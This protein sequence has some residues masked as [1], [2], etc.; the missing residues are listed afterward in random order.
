MATEYPKGCLSCNEQEIRTLLLARGVDINRFQAVPTPRHQW[1]DISVCGDCGQAWL[2]LPQVLPTACAAG[3]FSLHP[4]ETTMKSDEDEK[5]D[6]AIVEQALAEVERA[7]LVCTECGLDRSC[8]ECSLVPKTDLRAHVRLLCST[9][10]RR[11][12]EMTVMRERLS[13]ERTVSDHRNAVIRSGDHYF[14]CVQDYVRWIWSEPRDVRDPKDTRGRMRDAA[15]HYR[16]TRHDLDVRLSRAASVPMTDSNRVAVLVEALHRIRYAKEEGNTLVDMVQ[17]LSNIVGADPAA[18]DE[19]LQAVRDEQRVAFLEGLKTLGVPVKYYE[20]RPGPP[21]HVVL[22]VDGEIVDPTEYR[23]Y[24]DEAA[25]ANAIVILAHTAL[26]P[27]AA[28]ATRMEKNCVDGRSQ[29]PDTAEPVGTNGLTFGNVCA[30]RSLATRISTYLKDYKGDLWGV[31]A[32][33]GQCWAKNDHIMLLFPN[34]EEAKIVALEWS[35]REPARR[36]GYVWLPRLFE[37]SKDGKDA[38][39]RTGAQHLQ[40]AQELLAS[41]TL[42]EHTSKLLDEAREHIVALQTMPPRGFALWDPKRADWVRADTAMAWDP[43]GDKW[44][45]PAG[46]PM[47]WN[48]EEQARDAATKEFQRS[49]ARYE[50][51]PFEAHYGTNDVSEP[52]LRTRVEKYWKLRCDYYDMWREDF[53]LLQEAWRWVSFARERI[54]H[55]TE[56]AT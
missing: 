54:A 33:K 53:H 48:H 9:L 32:E 23:R 4:A 45:Q 3:T 41:R 42:F 51:R 40:Q 39:S 35:D 7:S 21:P 28:H 6:T 22:Q 15:E 19:F 38:R 25:A 8:M 30:A 43:K 24:E 10:V 5:I 1:S 37:P 13:R 46:S 50:V 14:A 2:I 12:A 29:M 16:T 49:D 20:P 52:S 56:Q 26:S 44:V 36:S 11:Q 17:K 34:E 31:W 47:V 27:F 18:D 55:L